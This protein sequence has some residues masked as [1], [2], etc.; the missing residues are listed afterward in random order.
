MTFRGEVALEIVGAAPQRAATV[1]ERTELSALQ[2][3]LFEVLIQLERKLGELCAEMD[4]STATAVGCGNSY[5][6]DDAVGDEYAAQL[7][8]IPHAYE[9]GMKLATS[10][11]G[12]TLDG[13]LLEGCE[14]RPGYGVSVAI[15]RSGT[16]YCYPWTDELE[17]WIIG[18][19]LQGHVPT[20]EEIT[21]RERELARG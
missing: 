18:Q 6:G 7:G 4:N 9:E 20:A 1:D 13:V 3:R 2:S 21:A 17:G 19:R 14:N 15:L 11:D 12:V 5:G 8:L 10:D 16:L